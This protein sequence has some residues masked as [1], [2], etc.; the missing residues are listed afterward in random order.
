M[1]QKWVMLCEGRCSSL[2]HWISVFTSCLLDMIRNWKMI[3]SSTI[4]H[5]RWFI[6]CFG[7]C[8]LDL[9]IILFYCQEERVF[10][11]AYLCASYPVLCAP[12]PPS[13]LSPPPGAPG[14]KKEGLGFLDVYFL[15]F[16]LD[17]HSH[18]IMMIVFWSKCHITIN[19]T[20]P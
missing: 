19:V 4:M 10:K 8:F 7:V 20:S 16:W 14:N 5:I 3:T 6:M 12:E 17:D 9:M 11:R 2:M 1:T 18:V 13:P 15:I